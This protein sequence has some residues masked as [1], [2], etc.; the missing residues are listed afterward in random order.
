MCYY[1]LLVYPGVTLKIERKNPYEWSTLDV[2]IT[3]VFE[4]WKRKRTSCRLL[5]TLVCT[6][7]LCLSWDHD[8]RL[9]EQHEQPVG[10]Y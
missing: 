7:R 2:N 8:R 9:G 10:L 4:Q 5:I 1:V 6:Q 3:M